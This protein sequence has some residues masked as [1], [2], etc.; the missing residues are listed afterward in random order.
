MN[1]CDLI[2]SLAGHARLA[3]ALHLAG[4]LYGVLGLT[5]LG[6]HKLAQPERRRSD[7]IVAVPS[8]RVGFA[9]IA[10]GLALQALALAVGA[11]R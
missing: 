4:L 8:P 9:L 3:D 5:L 2:A 7:G 6:W 11:C 1:A 10:L